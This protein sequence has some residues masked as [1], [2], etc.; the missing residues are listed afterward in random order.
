VKGEIVT[1]ARR[2]REEGSYCERGGKARAHTRHIRGHPAMTNVPEPKRLAAQ[3]TFEPEP[4]I[5]AE[6]DRRDT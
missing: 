2:A 6:K 3:A 1:G 5:R 4:P